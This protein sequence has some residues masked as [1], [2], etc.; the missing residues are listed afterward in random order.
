[1]IKLSINLNDIS[2]QNNPK[3]LYR[4][5]KE[6]S[7]KNISPIKNKMKKHIFIKIKKCKKRFR[8]KTI[9]FKITKKIQ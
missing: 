4:L 3:K 9:I 2:Y 7:K 5:S 6:N 8:R 1:M